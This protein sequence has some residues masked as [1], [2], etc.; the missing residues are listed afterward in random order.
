MRFALLDGAYKN[1]GDF[2]IA[3]RSK[4]LLKQVFPNCEILE[5]KRNKSLQKELADIN[6]TDCIILGGGPAYGID[7]Y[8]GLIKLVENLDDIKPPIISLGLG[9]WGQSPSF[10]EIEHHA[11]NASSM[12]LLQKMSEVYPLSCRD[13]ESFHVLKNAGFNAV[14]TGCV[15][16]YNAEFVNEKILKYNN[17][18]WDTICVSDPAF[19]RNYELAIKLV[20][21]I[22]RR[23]PEKKIKFIFH[24]GMG[25]EDKYTCAKIAQ[26]Q[27]ELKMKL[28]DRGIQCENIAFD[29]E[30]FHIYDNCFLHIGFRVH[31]HIYNLSIRQKSLL[32]EED[33]R[34]AGVNQA[35]GIPGGKAYNYWNP[36]NVNHFY[37]VYM[38]KYNH[39]RYVLDELRYLLDELDIDGELVYSQV[40]QRIQTY[41]KVMIN[42]IKG[43]QKILQDGK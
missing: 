33:S 7:M 20:D 12:K 13:W 29:S 11:F 41:Y 37:N 15:A 39:N 28:E 4:E 43:I 32:I 3:R 10:K 36:R 8:P 26:K 31:A 23:Y 18:K 24:R 25:E 40:F 5:Y 38:Q 6:T 9:W 14:M 16:W 22:K 1:A 30:G 17:V 2:L 19:V 35:L 21:F 27:M 42:Y 34:G